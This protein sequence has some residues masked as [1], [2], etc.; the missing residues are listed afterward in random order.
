MTRYNFDAEKHRHT[1]DGIALTGTSSVVGVLSKPLS[2]W[3]SGKAVEKLGWIH[4]KPRIN[5][6][7]VPTPLEVRIASAEPILN[8]IK[9]MTVMSYIELLDSAYRAHKDNLDSSADAGIDLHAD[10][11]NFVKCEMKILS[12][13]ERYVFSERIIPF[14][15]WSKKNVKKFL[16]S[17]AHSYSE[18]LFV[19]GISDVGALLKDGRTAIIDFKSAKDVY[20]SHFIQGAG[21]ALEVLENGLLTPD[22][23]LIQKVKKVDTIIIVAFGAAKVIP[24]ELEEWCKDNL[25]EIARENLVDYFIQEGFEPAVKLYGL[26]GLG[27]EK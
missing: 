3:A 15:E 23:E 8:D 17:E 14:I 4:P 7:Y 21:Y 25:P 22:G 13:K 9:K 26:M 16:W 24:V 11:E 20:L 5:G 1:L 27:K 2:W 6:K 19:G 12:E 10:L 18:R